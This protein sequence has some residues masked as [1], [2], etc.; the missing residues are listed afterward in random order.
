MLQSLTDRAFLSV[1][2]WMYELAVQLLRRRRAA[3]PEVQ[4]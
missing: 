3:T 2:S 1:F 4:L